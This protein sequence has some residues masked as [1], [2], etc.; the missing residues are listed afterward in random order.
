MIEEVSNLL[1]CIQVSRITRV[2]NFVCNFSLCH[3]VSK[4]SWYIYQFFC[5]LAGQYINLKTAK[6][7]SFFGYVWFFCQF[8]VCLSYVGAV[9]AIEGLRIANCSC[10]TNITVNKIVNDTI[11][12][13]LPDEHWKF[14]TAV[15]VSSIAAFMSY[16]LMTVFVLIPMDVIRCPCCRDECC[17]SGCCP[18]QCCCSKIACVRCKEALRHDSLSLYK[19]EDESSEMKAEQKIYFYTNYLIVLLL[20]TV[21]FSSSI[22][23]A[24]SDTVYYRRYGYGYC[25]FDSLYLAMILLQMSSQFCAIQSCFI[26]SKIIYKICNFLIKLETKMEQVNNENL[27]DERD[28]YNRLLEVDQNFINQVKYILDMLG[29]WFIFHWTLYALTTVLLSA[30]I[31]ETIIDVLMYD[32]QSANDLLPGKELNETDTVVPYGVYVVFFTFVHGHLFLYPCLRAAAIANARTKLISKIY[33]KKWTN[34]SLSVQTSFVQYLT[35]K[36]FAFRVPLC[37]AS[38]PIGFNW[39]FVSFF[40]PVLGAYLNFYNK[41][42]PLTST[43]PNSSVYVQWLP[44]YCLINN[45]LFASFA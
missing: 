13:T 5:F 32:F 20:F 8:V 44:G 42:L 41:D 22:A 38:I 19:D 4:S 29:V 24:V 34:L 1:E 2:I 16:V 18:D 35:S 37:C 27:D 39:V 11:E 31:I 25:W 3:F 40:V 45:D 23:Y 21:S 6:C 30:F 26:F 28:Y 33:K 12:C 36:N 43:H 17:S 9:F 14:T 10:F 7:F 15:I